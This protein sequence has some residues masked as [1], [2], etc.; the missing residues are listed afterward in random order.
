MVNDT[1][2]VLT[3]RWDPIEARSRSAPMRDCLPENGAEKSSVTRFGQPSRRRIAIDLQWGHPQTRDPVGIDGA[4]PS[5]EF[6]YGKFI[7]AA[8]FLQTDGAATHRIDYHRLA[9]GDP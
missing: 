2:N 8:N 1:A 9:P 6:F 3:A 7:T 5:E 4:L